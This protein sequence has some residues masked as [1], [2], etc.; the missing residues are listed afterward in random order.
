MNGVPDDSVVT[1]VIQYGD[2]GS[3]ATPGTFGQY[4]SAN[5]YVERASKDISGEDIYAYAGVYGTGSSTEGSRIYGR[6]SYMRPWRDS[7]PNQTTPIF[8]LYAMRGW[9]YGTS[10][11]K[12]G[13]SYYVYDNEANPFKRFLTVVQGLRLPYKPKDAPKRDS[14]DTLYAAGRKRFIGFLFWTNYTN[15]ENSIE[16]YDS[17]IGEGFSPREVRAILG[18]KAGT[19][20][21]AT[22]GTYVYS[23]SGL[24]LEDAGFYVPFGEGEDED[25]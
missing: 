6:L 18:L 19:D 2:S 23:N 16:I 21:T 17:W 1:Q 15:A 9:D 22:R 4:M 24:N 20:D 11:W 10:G 8:G 14:G 7:L 3:Y 12:T 13:N 5:Q 25:E